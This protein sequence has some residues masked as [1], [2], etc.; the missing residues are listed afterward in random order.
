MKR[1]ICVITGTRAEY[2]ILRWI[3]HAIHIDKELELQL[4]V[5]G[6]H[7]SP[8]F[9]L[10]FKQIELDGYLISKKIEVLLSSDTSVGVTKAMGLG[11]IS[12]GEI[13]NELK[14][15]I[16]IAAGDRFEMFTAVSAAMISLLPIAHIHGGE[17]SQGSID[18]YMRHAISKMSSIHF[19]STE[20]YRQR[21]IQL[22]E[23]P[24]RVF[25]T[26]SPGLDN[27]KNLKLLSRK[28]LENIINFSFGKKS[29]LVTF[30]STTL[31]PNSAEK[32]TKELILALDSVKDLKII[33]TY[34]NADTEGRIILN[35]ILDYVNRNPSKSIA[36]S[37][38]GQ[39]NYLSSLQFIDLVIGNSSSG[40]IE[41]PSFKKPT[42]N[43]GNRQKGR[44][45]AESV[46][47]ALPNKINITKA[48]KIALSSS[49]KEQLKNI[50]NPYEENDSSN[51][52]KNVLKKIDLKILKN[53]KFYDIN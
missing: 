4:L 15:D 1:K 49:F 20:T 25:N 9:G 24:N 12:F 7:L 6:T 50:E 5:T 48:I 10:T 14:P 27:I 36:I 47:N 21:V 37:S 26:G 39:L 3:I 52:I 23:H 41:V 2:G 42:I 53:K 19:T 33:F 22:G 8:E 34:P 35:I 18:E 17:L 43:I 51:K 44:I 31:E 29:A 46:I 32:Q 30:H 11:L 16:L 38:L 13:F 45:R 40:L 28:K